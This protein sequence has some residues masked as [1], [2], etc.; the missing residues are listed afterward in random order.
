[1]SNRVFVV[2]VGM[3]KFR[4]PQKKFDPEEPQF[5]EYATTAIS[6]AFDDCGLD[7]KKVQVAAVG[8]CMNTG[9]GQRCLYELGMTGIPI[10]NVA[11]ACATGSNALFLARSMVATG[12]YDCALALGIEIMKPGS[13]G[14]APSDMRQVTN[15]DNH[16]MT[17][18]SKF[19]LARAPI[20]PQM[21][22]NAGVEH[23]KKYGST[24]KHFAMIGEKNHRH[25]VNNPYSQFR[26]KYS[27]EQIEKARM[28]H[29]PLTKLQCSPTSDGAA[30]AIVCSEAFV[31]KH[32]LEGQA[33]EIVGQHMAT[34]FPSA[35]EAEKEKSCINMV[36]YDMAKY[37][38]D[39]VY[40][41]SG[42][43][44]KDV[45]VVELHDCFSCN[46]LIT[47]EALGLAKEGEGHKLV[48]RGD[49][50]YGGKW[51]VNPSGGLISKG[52]PLGATGLAQCA[53]LNWQ[54]RGEAGKRQVPNAK[55]ALQHNLGLGGCCVV[56]MYKKPEEWKNIPRKTKKNT[57]G[58][59]GFPEMK[60]RL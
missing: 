30:A 38:A 14:G 35:F 54:L 33:I 31:K 53:E 24:P 58:S 17:M 8:C 49:N 55:V 43:S 7:Y 46:E 26:D 32:G 2:G 56:T 40:N 4:K 59:A 6:R 60:A 41:Q 52:H 42:L 11:N 48:E 34:D 10:F 21:F 3:T 47:Y 19:P 51:V 20:M 15:F 39:N 50:T 13:L 28:V 23:M 45:Q 27:L 12:Q 25:S 18:L 57:A 44:P 37:C 16:M 5:P 29:H 1:M 22:G 36:G 9:N